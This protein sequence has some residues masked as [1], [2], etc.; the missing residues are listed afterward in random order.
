[1]IAT[2]T[3]RR[4]A[5]SRG[6]AVNARPSQDP[7]RRRAEL[8]GLPRSLAALSAPGSVGGGFAQ[9]HMHEFYAIPTR[10]RGEALES[11]D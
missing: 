6:V 11:C 1:M 7:G 5:S 3:E 8:E 4:P 2:A 10:R 9:K